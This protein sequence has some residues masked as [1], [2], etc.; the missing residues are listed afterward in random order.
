[1]T[2][3]RQQFLVEKLKQAAESN[4]LTK[5]SL[6]RKII[7]DIKVIQLEHVE[8]AT[9]D[10]VIEVLEKL[11]HQKQEELKLMQDYLSFAQSKLKEK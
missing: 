7:K 3:L 6:I 10:M 5:L 1:M 11:R 2:S 9:D 8:V 4:N